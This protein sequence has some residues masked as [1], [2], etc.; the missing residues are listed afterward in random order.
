[1]AAEASVHHDGQFAVNGRIITCPHCWADRGLTFTTS[2][3][4]VT[5]SCGCGHSW[6]EARVPASTVR[7]AAST[8]Q[9]LIHR[10]GRGTGR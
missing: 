5:G 4:H 9:R 6:V 2:G 1:M 7:E 10:S 3:S 8:P